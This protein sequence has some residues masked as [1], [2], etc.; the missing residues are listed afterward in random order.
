MTWSKGLTPPP[1]KAMCFQEA[2]A[3]LMTVKKQSSRNS[4]LGSRSLC[5]IAGGPV[6]APQ[7]FKL[8]V[9][10]S[11]EVLRC[12]RGGSRFKML[13]RVLS[14]QHPDICVGLHLRDQLPPFVSLSVHIEL[15]PYSEK[16]SS[17]TNE[18]QLV[19]PN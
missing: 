18:V 13:V 10:K 15:A 3:R 7:L 19:T 17:R 14:R 8:L 5:F 2:S 4:S 9:C 1:K 12:W 16:F 11:P 6:A